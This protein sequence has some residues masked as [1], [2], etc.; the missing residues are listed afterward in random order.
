MALKYTIAAST[1][2][3]T[4]HQDIYFQNLKRIFD[5]TFPNILKC[6]RD[7]DDDVRHVASTALEPVSDFLTQLLDPVIFCLK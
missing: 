7:N 6:L 1:A 3:V 5:L 2:L 4:N